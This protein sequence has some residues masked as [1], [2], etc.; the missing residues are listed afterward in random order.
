MSAPEC[1]IELLLLKSAMQVK[2][3][4]ILKARLKKKYLQSA[5]KNEYNSED[6][7]W[8]PAALIWFR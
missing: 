6:E 4:R 3:N 7:K 1:S 5:I 2:L 8:F